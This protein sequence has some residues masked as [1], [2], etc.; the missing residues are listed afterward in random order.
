MQALAEVCQARKG[1]ILNKGREVVLIS[2]ELRSIFGGELWS[3]F[4]GELWSIFGVSCGP[5]G[6]LW[7]LISGLSCGHWGELWSM[8]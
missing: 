2:V 1:L 4:W 3:I 6:E 5:W 7:S 8:G